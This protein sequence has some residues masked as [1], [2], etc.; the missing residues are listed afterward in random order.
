[1]VRHRTTSSD[2]VGGPRSD[3]IGGTD[4]DPPETTPPM[5]GHLRIDADLAR[6]ADIRRF[7][8]DRATA[9]DAPIECLEDLVQAVDEASTNVIVHGYRGGAGWLDIGIELEADRFIVRLEDEARPFDPTSV[10]E[11]DLSVPPMARK[12]G[13]MGIHLMREST[14]ALSYRPRPGGGNILTM[15]RNLQRAPREDA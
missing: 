14:D 5:S 13:G 10:P 15:S 2:R 8:R 9:A 1:V 7:V 12:P 4:P 11:P 3:T 6:L